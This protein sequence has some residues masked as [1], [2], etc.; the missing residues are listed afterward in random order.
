VTVPF[1]ELPAGGGEL[2]AGVAGLLA[3]LVLYALAKRRF[4]SGDSNASSRL[5]GLD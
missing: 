1:I 2:V 5:P 4:K 3:F